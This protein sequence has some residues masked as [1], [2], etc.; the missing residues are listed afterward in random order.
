MA[1]GVLVAAIQALLFATLAGAEPWTR[2]YVDALPDGAFAAVHVRPDGTKARHLP[3]HGADGR[4]DLPHLRSALARL[5]LV[6][7]EDP[8][9]AGRARLHLL[10]HR[11]ARREVVRVA[12]SEQSRPRQP[13]ERQRCREG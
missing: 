1:R 10:T 12:C 9:D 13:A 5:D 8:A 6:H 11:D 2:A 3:H 4:L 7:W